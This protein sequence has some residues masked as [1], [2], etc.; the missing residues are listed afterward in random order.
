MRARWFV[1]ASLLVA[2][3]T[4]ADGVKVAY[5]D[6]QRALNESDAGKKAK[7]DFKVVV[8]K[9]QAGLKKK[10]DA[11]DALKEQLDKKALVMKDEER[12]NLEEDYRKKMRDF[13]RDYKDSQTDL[14]AKD[15]E[16]TGSIIKDLQDIIRDYGER[17]NYTMIFEAS[18]T[19]VLYGTKNA[20]LTQAIL[21]EYNRKH[22]K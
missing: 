4:F 8:D 7:D 19:A 6:L 16:L 15:N 20:D 2:S 18:S 5:V 3:T 21:E 22:K 13:E 17:E 12:A 1:L 11:I 14:Q 10:K 9:V